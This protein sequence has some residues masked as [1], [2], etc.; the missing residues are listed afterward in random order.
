MR[1]SA[2]PLWEQL[3][4]LILGPPIMTALWWF[5]AR[6]WALTVQGGTASSKTKRRQKVEFYV[7]LVVMYV[8]GLGMA[9]YAWLR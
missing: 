5:A 9:L 1:P 4:I 3:I 2:A 6:G 7:V 8:V